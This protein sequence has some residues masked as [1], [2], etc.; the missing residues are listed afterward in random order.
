MTHF[1]LRW[2]K[3]GAHVHVRVYSAR[4]EH[5]THGKNGDLVFREDEWRDFVEGLTGDGL[6]EFTIQPDDEQS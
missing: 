6:A 1:R 2:K 5:Q 3:R 4:L